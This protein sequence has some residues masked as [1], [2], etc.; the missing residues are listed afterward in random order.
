[1]NDLEYDGSPLDIT[2]DLEGEELDFDIICP[3]C[4]SFKYK[5][6]YDKSMIL[7]AECGVKMGKRSNE[8]D[9]RKVGWVL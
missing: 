4:G 6:S 1:M 5:I 7:C 3:V 8:F 9:C 2:I